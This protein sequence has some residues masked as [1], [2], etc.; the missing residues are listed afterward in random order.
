MQVL[1]NTSKIYVVNLVVALNFGCGS[2][3]T[4]PAPVRSGNVSLEASSSGSSRVSTAYFHLTP[5]AEELAGRACWTELLGEC[6][7]WS[8]DAQVYA[9]ALPLTPLPAGALSLS[10]V[11]EPI[12]LLETTTGRYASTPHEGA[13]WAPGE[14][15]SVQVEGSD[16]FPAM[17]AALRSPSALTVLS[18]VGADELVLNDGQDLSL[19]W[20]KSGASNVYVM[21]SVITRAEGAEPVRARGLECNFGSTTSSAVL[22]SELL[23]SLPR[24]SNFESYR[25]DVFT[26]AFVNV[27]QDDSRLWFQA[28]DFGSSRALRIENALP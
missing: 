25:L 10:G 14:P 20:S 4:V 22:P 5:Q 28:T 19:S 3:K 27:T 21:L 26:A 7:L 13:L 8:C 23:A 15:L 16:D 6:E 9:E 24:P 1:R 12:E 11:S 17:Q 18:P 2:Q